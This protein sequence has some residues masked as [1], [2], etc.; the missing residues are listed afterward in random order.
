MA[1]FQKRRNNLFGDVDGNGKSDAGVGAGPADYLRVYPDNMTIPVQQR[2]AGIARIDRRVGLQHLRDGKWT[3]PT[4]DS[5][6]HPADD[7]TGNAEL[8]AKGIAQGNGHL[9]HVNLV[10]VAQRHRN[11]D[12][13]RVLDFN[14]CQIGIRVGAQNLGFH[15]GAVGQ[16]HRHPVGVADHVVIGDN[17]ALV[18]PDKAGPAGVLKKV[19]GQTGNSRHFLRRP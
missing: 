15:F 16:N 18:I 3:V 5:A 19:V 6:S 9:T 2:P 4:A 7:S 11:H 8:L 10:A 1:F 12:S 13:I 17:V 14:Y